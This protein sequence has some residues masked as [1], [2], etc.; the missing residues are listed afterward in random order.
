VPFGWVGLIRKVAFGWVGLIRRGLMY[1]HTHKLLWGYRSC[2]PWFDFCCDW[3][4]DW[5]SVA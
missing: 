1:T 3:L 5:L 2:G 4:I